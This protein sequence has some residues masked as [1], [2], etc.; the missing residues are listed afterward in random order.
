MRP[1][2]IWDL[3]EILQDFMGFYRIFWDIMGFFSGK[4]FRIF[5]E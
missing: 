2:G 5:K 4:V 1:Y 3:M